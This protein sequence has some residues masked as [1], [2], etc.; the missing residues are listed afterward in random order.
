M[1]GNYIVLNI[2]LAILLDNFEKT[3]DSSDTLYAEI[4]TVLEAFQAPLLSLAP[5]PRCI[6]RPALSLRRSLLDPF[7]LKLFM[8]GREHYYA[9]CVRTD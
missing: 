8:R 4:K 5:A 3:T 6:G 1:I 2:F 9:A 7:A